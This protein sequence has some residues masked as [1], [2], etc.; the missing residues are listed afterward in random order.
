MHY[1]QAVVLARFSM[2]QKCN[3]LC[4]E[5]VRFGRWSALFRYLLPPFFCFLR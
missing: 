4:T 5:M 2:V 3:A 1:K